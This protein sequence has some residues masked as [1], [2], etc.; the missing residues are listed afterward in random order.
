MSA[1]SPGMAAPPPAPS[2]WEN[3]ARLSSSGCPGHRRESLPPSRRPREHGAF[4]QPTNDVAEYEMAFL[5]L[6][7]IDRWHF[8][9]V[10]AQLAHGTTAAASH[11]DGG[12][13]KTTR[14]LKGSQDVR[15]PAGR[16]VRDQHVARPRQGLQLA[17]E[18]LLVAVVVADR[19]EG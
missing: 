2:A 10:I 9:Q 19:G 3:P 12:D 17:G 11:P 15:R 7:R 1:G 14:A 18:E 13:R 5:N 6:R 4:D 16:R 8:E